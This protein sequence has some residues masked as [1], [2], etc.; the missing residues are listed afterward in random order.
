VVSPTKNV[1][2]LGDILFAFGSYHSPIRLEAG[3]EEV[4]GVS[5]PSKKG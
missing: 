4:L 2:A 3:D 5:D 1:K